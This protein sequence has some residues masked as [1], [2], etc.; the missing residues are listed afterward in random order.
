MIRISGLSKRFGPHPLFRGL[1]LEI[2][3][4][5]VLV[6]IGPSG[7]GKSTLLRCLNGLEPF[8]EGSILVDG[9]EVRGLA[10]DRTTSKDREALR[11]V[12]RKVG[13]VF[14]HFN[15]FPHLTVL[16]NI[17]EAPLR[18]LAL[19]RSVAEARARTLLG[20]VRLAGKEHVYPGSLSGGEKQRVAIAR[21]LA[22]QPAVML[23]DEPTSALDPE[24]IGEVLAVIRD[25]AGEGMTMAI[26]THEMTFAAEVADRVAVLDH[27]ELIE[28]GPPK[29][30]FRN[31][32]QERT[33]TFLARV[34]GRGAGPGVS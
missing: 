14:Q 6:L 32:A 12:R 15:L 25:L 19:A 3:R 18:V 8:S 2:A 23:F 17:M 21:A 26:A 10:G 16:G 28:V 11:R 13:M 5:E 29:Q 1:S 7:S 27:G 34:L 30:V 31:P 22:M 20:K 24:T 33:R 9:V 4:G